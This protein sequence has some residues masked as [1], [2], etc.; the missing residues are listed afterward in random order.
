MIRKVNSENL[1]QLMDTKD[2]YQKMMKTIKAQD[3]MSSL[4][5]KMGTLH[6][7]H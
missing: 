2:H 4:T 1:N 7:N 6:M 3:T 5:G